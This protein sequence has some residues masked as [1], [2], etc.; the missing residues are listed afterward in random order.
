MALL[1]VLLLALPDEKPTKA[2]IVA[3]VL[4]AGPGATLQR[5]KAA[6]APLRDMDLLCDGDMVKAG[7]E[8]VRLVFLEGGQCERLLT[9]RKATVGK[10]GCA[11]KEAVEKLKA[12]P[13]AAGEKLYRYLSGERA[14][15]AALTGRRPACWPIH[16]SVSVK[17]RPTF[18]WA[19]IDNA[20]KYEVE[21]YTGTKAKAVVLCKET[22]TRT[23]FP[24]PT[25]K[26]AL[27]RGKTYHWTVKAIKRNGKTEI[28]V[29]RTDFT[30]ASKELEKELA[31]L[32]P[33]LKS[34]DHDDWLLAAQ[35]FESE[36][37]FGKA[38]PLYDKLARERPRQV[39]L[40]RTLRDLYYHYD[41]DRALELNKRLKELGDEN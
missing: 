20:V 39:N 10:V 11:P 9:G 35:V 33:L 41:R 34:K 36:A 22:T 30:I 37:C 26:E 18:R 38:L 5:G 21:V 19:G 14:G 12:R 25:G 16:R 4:Q 29:E 1:I 13:A 8:P 40:L 6:A 2:P 3:M 17:L 24:Y 32:T 28:V 7:K 23:E 15:V 31:E 27:Q